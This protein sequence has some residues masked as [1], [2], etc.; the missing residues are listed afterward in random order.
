MSAADHLRRLEGLSWSDEDRKRR[1]FAV[2][3]P[4][5]PEELAALERRLPCPLPDDARALLAVGRGVDGG[6]LESVDFGG[7]LEDRLE[8]ELFPHVLP[9][10][11]DG[12]GNYW[13]L[14]LLP[15]ST[16]W[17]PVY[18]VC[19]DPAVVV[20]QCA[21]VAEFLDGM[22]AMARPPHKGPLDD[23]HEG[24]SGRIWAEQPGAVSQAAALASA[25]PELRAFAETLSPEWWIV[26]LRGATTGAG[27]A[28]GHFGPRS[29]LARYGTL[30]VFAYA[31]P[32]KPVSWWQRLLGG[33][34]P[35]DTR[36]ADPGASVE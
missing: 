31:P 28:W 15:E 3:P 20:Y 7:G 30:A 4:L 24:A 34:P 9:I 13:V 1:V 27:L 12:Y 21:D 18:F 29:R 5:S 22:L 17:G 32:V 8:F 26:D 35:G 10:A 36:R 25:D 19:H 14:D 23:V 16:R 33:G 2:L 6:P 11:H